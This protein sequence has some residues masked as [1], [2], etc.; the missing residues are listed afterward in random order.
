MPLGARHSKGQNRKMIGE[1]CVQ[2]Y[3]GGARPAAQD[4]G[5]YQQCWGIAA[6]GTLGARDFIGAGEGNRTLVVS[7]GSFC[8]TIELHP[9]D[10]HSTRVS[11]Y[12]TNFNGARSCSRQAAMLIDYPCFTTHWSPM[13]F[14]PRQPMRPACA[15]PPIENP[16]WRVGPIT[17]R[18]RDRPNA[19]K[20]STT[21]PGFALHA[22]PGTAPGRQ[23]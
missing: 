13:I 22:W 9:R 1:C 21:R 17:R 18:A 23:R 7:L 5:D 10:P 19:G 4:F 6:G 11:A 14:L 12:L 8:S 15:P 16:G 3:C 20:P 2:L